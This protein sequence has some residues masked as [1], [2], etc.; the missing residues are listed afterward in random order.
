MAKDEYFREDA[1][2][3]GWMDLHRCMSAFRVLLTGWSSG[4]LERGEEKRREEKSGFGE[5]LVE[6]RKGEVRSEKA[7]VFELS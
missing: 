4:N 3:D 5:R 7:G 2:W 1:H 6:A